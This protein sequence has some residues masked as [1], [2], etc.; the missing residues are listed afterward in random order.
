M[1]T[2]TEIDKIPEGKDANELYVDT[3]EKEQWIVHKGKKY[4]IKYRDMSWGEKNSTLSSMLEFDAKGGKMSLNMRAYNLKALQTILVSAPFKISE[5]ILDRLDV[6]VGEQLEKII[7][8]PF[9]AALTD[10]AQKK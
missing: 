1:K 6:A 8:K 4:K 5:P 3:S 9:Q 2:E 7:P 10:V